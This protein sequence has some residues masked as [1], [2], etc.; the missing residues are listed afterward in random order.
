MSVDNMRA[1]LVTRLVSALPGVVAVHPNEKKTPPANA[2]WVKVDFSY[3]NPVAITSGSD[4]EDEIVGF[5]QVGVSGE[6]GRG[7]AEIMA[8]VKLILQNFTTGEKLLYDGQEILVTS[9]GRGAGYKMDSLWRIPVTVNFLGR[10]Q[11]D[12]PVQ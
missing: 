6:T 1:A 2:V 3:N 4:G 9:S 8:K 12:Q 5:M 10:Y 7:E 11:R